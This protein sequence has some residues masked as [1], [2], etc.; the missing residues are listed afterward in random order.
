MATPQLLI[1]KSDLP[2]TLPLGKRQHD[3]FVYHLHK[4]EAD[5]TVRPLSLLGLS[6]FGEIGALAP[7]DPCSFYLYLKQT[8]KSPAP[9][10]ASLGKSPAW[11]S[12]ASTGSASTFRARQTVWAS[13]RVKVMSGNSA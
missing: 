12:V 8:P 7:D 5:G 6:F 9:T 4:R 2:E 13:A 1:R 11:G 10:C 3:P